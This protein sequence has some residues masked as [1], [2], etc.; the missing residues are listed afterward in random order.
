MSLFNTIDKNTSTTYQVRV[1]GLTLN[2]STNEAFTVK[3]TELTT[4]ANPNVLSATSYARNT[5]TLP[6][7]STK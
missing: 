2:P 4:T 1:S 3:L 6:L 5:E 7:I